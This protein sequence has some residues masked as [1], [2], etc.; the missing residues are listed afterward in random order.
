MP[1]YRP[2]S[3]G[4]GSA[5]VGTSAGFLDG[6]DSYFY[7]HMSSG[8]LRLYLLDEVGHISQVGEIPKC[9]VFTVLSLSDPNAIQWSLL[10]I[11][12]EAIKA[13]IRPFCIILT[14]AGNVVCVYTVTIDKNNRKNLWIDTSA[15]LSLVGPVS[16]LA[17]N[18]AV[19]VASIGTFICAYELGPLLAGDTSGPQAPIKLSTSNIT[20]LYVCRNRPAEFLFVNAASELGFLN[21]DIS[22]PQREV[23][24]GNSEDVSDDIFI[25][26]SAYPF[27]LGI[28]YYST[29]SLCMTTGSMGMVLADPEDGAIFYQNMDIRPLTKSH[30]YI[31]N[32]HKAEGSVFVTC[33]K[34]SGSVTVFKLSDGIFT[35]HAVFSLPVSNTQT[36]RNTRSGLSPAGV[37]DTKGDD[38]ANGAGS[39][40]Q[41]EA[42][43]SVR[44][45]AWGQ[46]RA[47]LLDCTSTI[48][49]YE[50]TGDGNLLHMHVQAPT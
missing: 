6:G 24:F 20:D 13:G 38:V 10:Q 2:Y 33:G 26:G 40:E 22:G 34:F 35:R 17:T 31:L 42:D 21:L 41:Q 23:L 7:V 16:C 3:I 1:L 32:V 29:E 43:L 25:F 18:G 36:E 4:Q 9:D 48:I 12:P 44:S 49:A 14:A 47:L 19:L 28:V 37:A 30:D 8:Y 39:D 45:I 5:I 46:K 27:P 15:E 50:L 11:D